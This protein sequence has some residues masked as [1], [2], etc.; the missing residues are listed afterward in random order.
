MIQRPDK[1]QREQILQDYRPPPSLAKWFHRNMAAK[2]WFKETAVVR[3]A[4]IEWAKTVRLH[5]EFVRVFVETLYADENL[6]DLPDPWRILD[7]FIE[8]HE[9]MIGKATP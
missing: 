6:R 7:V 2:M 8:E 1:K 3:W 9:A 5:E 4:F